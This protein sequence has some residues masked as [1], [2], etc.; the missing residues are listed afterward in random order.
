MNGD[1][2]VRL[3][4]TITTVAKRGKRPPSPAEVRKKLSTGGVGR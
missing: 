4:H 1:Q 2:N 3:S